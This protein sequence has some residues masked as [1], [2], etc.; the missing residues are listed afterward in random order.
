[1]S[2]HIGPKL[3][4]AAVAIVI[5]LIVGA[6]AGSTSIGHLFS[7]RVVLTFDGRR[8]SI[9]PMRSAPP[10]PSDVAPEPRESH[11]ARRAEDSNEAHVAPHVD[12]LWVSV[13]SGVTYDLIQTGSH[14]EM[15]DVAAPSGPVVVGSGPITATGLHLRYRDSSGRLRWSLTL[16][17]TEDRRL[18]GQ[19]L[20]DAGLV[21]QQVIL[22][23]RDPAT[24][25]AA[26]E[27]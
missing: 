6:L 21:R 16:E 3:I 12:G 10:S 5:S 25:R 11:P 20:D 7:Y 2:A 18:S 27:R 19:L 8:E 24:G 9:P 22:I 15:V 17:S 1:M 13:A 14:V 26:D 23:R 4:V